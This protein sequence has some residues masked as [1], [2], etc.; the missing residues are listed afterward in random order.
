MTV[1]DLGL[2]DALAEEL[3]YFIKELNLNEVRLNNCMDSL[4]W[5]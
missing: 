3:N 5:S 2:W 4:V 1:A